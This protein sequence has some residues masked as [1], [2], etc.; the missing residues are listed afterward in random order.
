MI[1]IIEPIREFGETAGCALSAVLALVASVAYL[2]PSMIMHLKTPS[3]LRVFATTIVGI[4]LLGLGGVFLPSILTDLGRLISFLLSLSLTILGGWRLFRAPASLNVRH[5]VVD[6]VCVSIV[7]LSLLWALIPPKDGLPFLTL[8]YIFGMPSALIVATLHLRWIMDQTAH[9]FLAFVEYRILSISYPESQGHLLI[10]YSTKPEREF[11]VFDLVQGTMF[12][13]LL[14]ASLILGAWLGKLYII[15]VA[16]SATIVALGVLTFFPFSFWSASSMRRGVRVALGGGGITILFFSVLRL[17]WPVPPEE[18]GGLKQ[19]FGRGLAL[20]TPVLLAVVNL[21]DHRKGPVSIRR[22]ALAKLLRGQLVLSDAIHHALFRDSGARNL[23]AMVLGGV[24]IL[25]LVIP[26]SRGVLE[27]IGLQSVG[28]RSVQE[29][30]EFFRTS[31]EVWDTPQQGDDSSI[32]RFILGNQGLVLLY[33]LWS[34]VSFMRWIT[35]YDRL[36]RLLESHHDFA[37]RIIPPLSVIGFCIYLLP[38]LYAV[39]LMIPVLMAG[40]LR[41]AASIVIGAFVFNLFIPRVM[42]FLWSLVAFLVAV[43]LTIGCEDTRVA[44]PGE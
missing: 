8:S 4:A 41:G 2:R 22:L 16:Y 25:Y 42:A 6:L 34:L 31:S 33:L 39:V 32:A 36:E 35:E 43:W 44:R 14:G 29:A 12:V 11:G 40:L 26:N 19:I 9:D 5:L 21:W 37:H 27:S 17:I 18:V 23:M 13:C 24:L 10:P 38:F 20:S 15:R 28:G 30:I 3:R 7:C 1:A